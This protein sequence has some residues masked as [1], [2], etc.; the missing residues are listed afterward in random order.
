[1]CKL[2]EAW[3]V[4]LDSKDLKPSTIR[5]DK[6]RYHCHLA[7][8]WGEKDL[9]DVKT[10]DIIKYKKHL[11]DNDLA[12]QSVKH[13]LT[14]LR[15]I[16]KR[17]ILLE[18]YHAPLPTF[19]MP[20]FDNRRRRYLSEDEATIM[21][22]LLYQKSELWH[23][24]TLVALHTGM[25]ASEILSIRDTSINFALHE[26]TLFDTKNG[27]SRVIPLNQTAF[28]ILVKY[29]EQ[30][31]PYF[32]SKNKITG[33]SQIYRDTV[34]KTNLNDNVVDGRDKVVFHTLR[35]TF[36]SWL[37]QREI[38]LPIVSNLLGHKSLSMTMRYAHLAPKQG[39][40]AV[41]LLP[42]NLSLGYMS[43]EAKQDEE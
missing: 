30:K 5:N 39:R 28:E 9:E 2:Y 36:A 12:P 1:M 13:C 37:V 18:L 14:L 23:D 22:S 4:Y 16:M 19:E 7:P 33:V 32:F 3:E 24:I 38:A 25:R 10:L 35:H 15:S 42:N 43:S 34:K 41:N 6:N 17:A 31:L 20:K 21:L 11:S 40:H 8:Y 26:L 27:M 29:S